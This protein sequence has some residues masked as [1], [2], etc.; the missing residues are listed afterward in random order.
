MPTSG[1]SK[2]E[3]FFYEDADGNRADAELHQPILDD[4]DHA[5]AQ[6]V[7]RKVAKRLGLSDE[8][9]NKLMRKPAK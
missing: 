2:A 6:A 7:S 1:K 5:K 9:I 8:Q 3:E 4:G